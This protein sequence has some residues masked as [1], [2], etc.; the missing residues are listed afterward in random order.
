M[1]L[2][3]FLITNKKGFDLLGYLITVATKPTLPWIYPAD[4]LIEVLSVKP[5]HGRVIGLNRTVQ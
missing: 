1:I 3:I 5:L 2:S 4:C